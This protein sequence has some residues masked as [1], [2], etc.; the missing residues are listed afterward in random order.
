MLRHGC[1]HRSAPGSLEIIL[2][3][4]NGSIQCIIQDNGI[5]RIAAGKKRS[6]TATKYKSMGMGITESRIA[7]RNR[8]SELG[9]HVE[10]VD[11]AS[12]DNEAMG[13]R[14]IIHIP[15]STPELIGL[16]NK[17]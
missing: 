17:Q 8:I 5:G 9:I 2:S 1:L 15:E 11:L 4:N 14:V 6:K 3:K 7:L 12:S 10:I 16:R 13:T